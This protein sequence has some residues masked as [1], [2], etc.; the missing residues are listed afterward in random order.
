MNFIFAFILLFSASNALAGS[1]T[2]LNGN[3]MTMKLSVEE[4]NVLVVGASYDLR[5]EDERFARITVTRIYPGK[6]I[7]AIIEQRGGEALMARKNYYL[8]ENDGRFSAGPIPKK[9]AKRRAKDIAN[10]P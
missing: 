3:Y 6:G 10:G 5:D 9:S 1:L 2:F 4:M 8:Y 7:E